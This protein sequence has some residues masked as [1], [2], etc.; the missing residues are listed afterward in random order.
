MIEIK[1]DR[2]RR[3][4]IELFPEI[5]ERLEC[6]DPIHESRNFKQFQQFAKQGNALHIEAQD[7]V[8]EVLQ[9]EQ[10]ES[11]AATQVQHTFGR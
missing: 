6:I 3:D 5:G 2:E 4:P 7:G 8:A 10:K 11:A 9:N 1:I